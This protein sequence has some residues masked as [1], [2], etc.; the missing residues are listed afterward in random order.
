MK[1]HEAMARVQSED[2]ALTAY[3][4]PVRGLAME[5][6]MLSAGE[7]CFPFTEKSLSRLCERFGHRPK[8]PANYLWSLTSGLRNGLLQHHLSEGIGGDGMISLFS[9]GDELIG[10]GRA[11]LARLTGRD[12]LEAACAGTG[13][14][15]EDLE[16]AQL[17][18]ED[19]ALRFDLIVHRASH[20]VRRGDVV[21]AGVR[22]AHSLT[23]DFA[24]KVEGYLHR[25]ICTNGAVHRECVGPREVPRTRRLPASHPQAKDQRRKQVHRLV[26]NALGTLNRRFEGLERLTS[27]RVDFE[28]FAT[29]WLRRSRLS[30]HRLLPLLRQAHGEEGGEETAYGVMN[31]FTR[32]ATHQAELSPNIRDVLARLGG[33]L[34]FG[35]SRVCS[36]CWSLIAA[37]N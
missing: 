22:V 5:G 13:S 21:T 30:P 37:S 15:D 33:M 19:E 8:V 18:V 14:R 28:H 35:H 16:V 31:A 34:A 23:G 3:P 2:A 6:G 10:F 36:Q 26:A 25:L 12:V 11:D 1:A 4:V 7:Q 17:G 29:P 32:V 20:E 9:R 27:E 24:T